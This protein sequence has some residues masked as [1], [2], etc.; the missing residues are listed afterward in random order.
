MQPSLQPDPS[1]TGLDPKVAGLL[2]YLGGFVTG[3]IFLVLEKQSRYVR[4]HAMQSTV[5]CVGLIVLNILFGFIPLIGLFLNFLLAPI[6]LILW[7]GLMLLALQGRLGKLPVI[8]DWCEQQANR[9]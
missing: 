4:L 3:I 6:G 1:S 2:C 9:F 7:I 8:G 5:V